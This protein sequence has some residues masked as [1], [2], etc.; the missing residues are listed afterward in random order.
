MRKV[1]K[2]K[3]TGPLEGREN[4]KKKR[5]EG[6]IPG[7]KERQREER[8]RVGGGGEEK[9]G[10]KEL[11]KLNFDFGDAFQLPQLLQRGVLLRRRKSERELSSLASRCRETTKPTASLGD[12]CSYT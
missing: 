12:S 9:W 1:V 2:K 8:G 10:K 7:E 3:V 5:R 4:G 6:E 11:R